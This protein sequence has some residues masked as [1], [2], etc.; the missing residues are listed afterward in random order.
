M[1]IALYVGVVIAS[2]FSVVFSIAS[3]RASNPKSRGMHTARM[4]VSMGLLLVLLAFVQFIL[5]EPDTIRIVLGS[6]FLL[7]GLFNGFAGIRNY[8]IFIKMK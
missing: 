4:N 6:L 1:E 3:R 2:V 8:G 5:F 7:L